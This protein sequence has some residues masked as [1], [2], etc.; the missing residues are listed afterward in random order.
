MADSLPGHRF[1]EGYVVFERLAA[2]VSNISR[3]LGE[4]AELPPS[5]FQAKAPLALVTSGDPT[6]LHIDLYMPLE[7][8]AALRNASSWQPG[9]D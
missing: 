8:L 9:K 5:L 1:A 7:V 3:T 4:Q 2:M 6:S